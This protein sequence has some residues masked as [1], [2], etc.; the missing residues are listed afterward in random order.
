MLRIFKKILN[1]ENL[2]IKITFSLQ[3]SFKLIFLVSWVKR[4]IIV[5]DEYTV[6][7]IFLSI[8]KILNSFQVVN[9]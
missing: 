8:S 3:V 2:Q 7:K 1:V 4:I 5:L 6:F 9:F